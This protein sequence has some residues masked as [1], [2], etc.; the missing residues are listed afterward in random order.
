MRLAARMG[1]VATVM[2]VAVVGELSACSTA[3][4]VRQ[5]TAADTY[6]Q[7]WNQIEHAPQDASARAL[8]RRRST[9][10]GSENFANLTIS[11]QHARLL[12]T[13]RIGIRAKNAA[14]AYGLAVRASLMPDAGFADWSLR[15]G[16][17]DAAGNRADGVRD[18]T[19]LAQRW[20][21]Q[22]KKVNV[23]IV[24]DLANRA[25]TSEVE[26]RRRDALL[27]ALYRDSWV[28][29]YGVSPSWLW[30]DLAMDLA[31]SG[32]LHRAI[33]VVA[34]VDAPEPLL[35]MQIDKRFD[36][37]VRS[38][39]KLFDVRAGADREIRVWQAAIARNPRS[40]DVIVQLT[41]ADLYAARYADAE[42]LIRRVFAK[43]E[44]AGS[45]AALYDDGDTPLNW[46]YDNLAIALEARQNR[47]GAASAFRDAADRPENGSQN[48]SNLIN[49]AQYEADLG[50]GDVAVDL[51]HQ[52]PV[53]SDQ[54]SAFG[55]MQW[56]LVQLEAS[57]ENGNDPVA[58]ESLA[59]LRLHQ[60]DAL[61]AYATGLLADNQLD[62]AA[63]LLKRRLNDPL[64]RDQALMEI[65]D[66][67]DP[68]LPPGKTLRLQRL[69]Q[70]LQRRDVRDVVDRVGRIEHV[71]LPTFLG[72]DIS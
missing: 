4:P 53:D 30:G 35:N 66:Y 9:L 48:V 37:L 24:D 61:Q 44:Q 49:L 15:V 58:Q 34:H 38:N 60:K 3:P 36:A 46:L 12:E 56:Y 41:Y 68:P 1:K 51:L 32:H 65:Q 69:Q 8:F 14:E 17:A 2:L 40:L 27:N 18:L 62:E 71:S 52:L 5:G 50:N 64:T 7:E 57:V 33:R 10:I 63:S 16:A 70:V 11:L 20:P 55:R 47:D 28:A 26:K 6:R 19:K 43:I 25:P 54:M 31:E 45:L 13:A 59:Y 72:V 67:A 22:L 42:S 21:A 23:D 29:D 39:P